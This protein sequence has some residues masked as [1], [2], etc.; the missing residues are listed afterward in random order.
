MDF[1]DLVIDYIS[2]NLRGVRVRTFLDMIDADERYARRFDELN[3]LYA[4][5]L[6][7]HFEAARGRNWNLLHRRMKRAS[8]KK[9]PVLRWL[10]VAAALLIRGCI[11]NRIFHLEQWGRAGPDA[12]RSRC[13]RGVAYFFDSSR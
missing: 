9:F 6:M 12:L 13:S 3:R 2:G 7:P 10:Y 1:D 11:W 4:C 8:V 5:S